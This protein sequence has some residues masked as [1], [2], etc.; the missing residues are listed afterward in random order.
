VWRQNP[1]KKPGQFLWAL[2][3]L[4]NWIADMC[5][6][7]YLYVVCLHGCAYVSRFKVHC[8]SVLRPGAFKLPGR[9]ASWGTLAPELT[10]WQSLYGQSKKQKKITFFPG[11]V[12]VH[13]F[14]LFLSLTHTHAHTHANT[15]TDAQVTA[16]VKVGLKHTELKL[17]RV[18]H[19]TGKCNKVWFI[20]LEWVS[21]GSWASLGSY[22]T[23]CDCS[24]R[25]SRASCVVA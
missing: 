10:V 5:V 20:T 1:K 17:G 21:L 4:R 9:A 2:L 19:D 23:T 6:L 16:G 14:A 13:S 15:H 12:S 18:W 8:G 24:W 7:F 22:Y 3:S 11:W 25:N